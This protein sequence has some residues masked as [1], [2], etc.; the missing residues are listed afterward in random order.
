MRPT[1]KL[2]YE[3][4]LSL[5]PF[6]QMTSEKLSQVAVSGVLPSWLAGTE[7]AEHLTNATVMAFGRP[8][9][10]ESTASAAYIAA[11]YELCQLDTSLYECTSPGRLTTID[12]D[13]R[14][15]VAS[16]VQVPLSRWSG[17]GVEF[18]ATSTR[19][20]DAL[21]QRLNRI[22]DGY[23]PDRLM[24][25]GQNTHEPVFQEGLS[26]SHAA[27]LLDDHRPHLADKIVAFEAA[28]AAKDS[29]ESQG[30]DCDEL[31]ECMELRR[32]ADTIAGKYV[33]PPKPSTWVKYRTLEHGGL[34]CSKQ[35][36][37]Q[38]R[39][40]YVRYMALPTLRLVS[41]TATRDARSLLHVTRDRI[42][43]ALPPLARA[44][45][46]RSTRFSSAFPVPA[47]LSPCKLGFRH[48]VAIC[49]NHAWFQSL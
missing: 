49:A 43:G 6:D 19:E 31:E 45:A 27:L 11:G 40:M 32:M 42:L 34:Q 5:P 10:I 14:S 30:S 20:P 26:A 37:E 18:S 15:I 12:V 33:S 38:T 41:P 46:P 7:Y 35:S 1:T 21:I 28:I 25:S 23:R 36:H 13:D 9:S 2:F 47:T 39:V 44:L 17:A 4:V 22:V 3:L 16:T 8:I 24:L 48:L 29:L